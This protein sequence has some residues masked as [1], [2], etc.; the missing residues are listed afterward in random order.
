MKN[1]SVISK[2]K[3]ISAAIEWARGAVAI[4]LIYCMIPLGVLDVY[5]QEAPG[6]RAEYQQ[7]GEERLHQLVAPIALYPDAL[8]AQVLAA[9]TFSPQ[10]I[11]AHRFVEEH[12]GIPATDMA[13]LVDT[14]PWDP[15]VKALTAF[16]SVLAN[17]D[18]NLDWTNKLGDAYYNQPQDVMNAVQV[19]RQRA[20][21]AGTLKTTPEERVVY[22]PGSIVI[23]PV[24]PAVYYVPV[25]NPWLVYGAPVPVYPAYYYPPSPVGAVV[26][27][28]AIGFTAGVLVGAFASYGWGCPHWAPNWYSHTVVFNRTTYISHSTTVINHGFY[29]GF[30][31]DAVARS[32]NQRIAY[33]PHGG[34]YTDTRSYSNGQYSNTRT[35][36]G[37]HGAMYSDTRTAGNGQ[38]SNTRTASGAHGATYS[39]T[40]TAGNGEYNNSRSVTGPRGGTYH[41]TRTDANGDYNNTR[42]ATGP[43]GRTYS[44]STSRYA[45]GSTHSV[46]GP[47]GKTETRTVT[48][49]GTGDATITRSGPNG[50]KTRNRHSRF[51]KQG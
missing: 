31:H 34:T 37:P 22:R 44:S 8:V 7:L 27:A 24:S 1:S 33:G 51:H 18:R 25:Y 29:G 49:K 50:S 16:P 46:T 41:D 40:R 42:T 38:Y 20:Y 30:D 35:A 48:G 21:A 32:Y 19:M 2:T 15:S 43:N 45:D 4:L 3:S 9:A 28:A 17:L 5:A 14:K 39:D 47:N 11:E 36:T 26:A 10:V 6:A 13:R 23:A 12:R